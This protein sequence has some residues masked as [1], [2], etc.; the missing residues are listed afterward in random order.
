MKSLLQLNA[1][2]FSDGG[3]STQLA[4]EFV[5]NWQLGN[6]GANIVVR[7]LAKDAIPHLTAERLQA[8]LSEPAQRSTAQGEIV[9]FSD[10]L[11]AE[12]NAADVVVMGLPMYNFG[13]PSALQAYFDHLAR[14]GVTF[15]YTA[16]GPAGIFTNKR[17]LIFAARGGKYAGTVT[18]SE[19]T[20]VRTFLALLGMQ[21][22]EFVY[23]EGLNIDAATRESGLAEA[24]NKGA[25]L[26]AA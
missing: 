26:A 4:N 22:V 20:H 14:A 2:I 7:D 23:A 19:T 6:P 21:D 24:R 5:R 17:V 12:L 1:S 11:I 25:Q 9:A 18:D 10:A 8:L 3:Q 15:K 13:I 16:Q